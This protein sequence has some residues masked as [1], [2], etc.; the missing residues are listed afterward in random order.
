M[1][2]AGFRIDC[3]VCKSE[4]AVEVEVRYGES[5]EECKICGYYWEKIS[6][7]SFETCEATIL[8]PI[9]VK[10]SPGVQEVSG[11]LFTVKDKRL[12]EGFK[13]CRYGYYIR[14]GIL[15]K[16]PEQKGRYLIVNKW[17]SSRSYIPVKV[18]WN[19]DPTIYE[20]PSNGDGWTSSGESYFLSELACD[21]S[22]KEGED[23]F[24]DDTVYMRNIEHRW[25]RRNKR[26]R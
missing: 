15:Q 12:L 2:T 11:S 4:D 23:A 19:E 10:K 16:N 9:S 21:N 7:Y 8:A 3:S 24:D 5:R 13:L 1:A 20:I 17:Y 6:E 25:K 22:V 26:G 18:I 14:E